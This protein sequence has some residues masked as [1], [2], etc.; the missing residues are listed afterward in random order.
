MV[1]G[2]L[3]SV[4]D[5]PVESPSSTSASVVSEA[6]SLE[7]HAALVTRSVIA[8]SAIT[9]RRRR[10]TMSACLMLFVS[11]RWCAPASVSCP[12]GIKVDVEV[13]YCFVPADANP[14]RSSSVI[15][16]DFG[17][18]SARAVVV[19]SVT[20][21]TL[22]TG[23]SEY[24][25]GV[26]D[27]VL[28]RTGERLPPDW[29]LQVPRDYVESMVAAVRDAM[30]VAQV[31]P[32][33]V[34]GI[35]TDFTACTVLPTTADG[36]P[37]CEL[38]DFADRPHAYVKLWK[39]HAAQSHAD[40]LN[41]IAHERG[42]RW[43]GRY[44]GR[45]SSEWEL[46][47][48][49]QLLEEDPEVY[50]NTARWVEAADW[51]VWQLCGT[52]VRN[53]CATGFKAAWQDGAYPSTAYFAA[54]NPAFERF[55]EEKVDQPI[56]RLGDRA[57]GL[58]AAMSDATRPAGGDRRERRQ[59]RCPRDGSGG[60]G[61]RARTTG[62]HHGHVHLSCDERQRS[63]RRRGHLRGGRGRHRPRT[64]GLRGGP[65]WRRR[66]LRLVRRSSGAAIGAR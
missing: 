28:P 44:G 27:T 10:R 41:R 43:I 36:T 54:V 29:A 37:L 17:T 8:A 25:H 16:V 2:R 20:G 19:D 3:G 18:L 7:E 11:S 50:A 14:P 33:T 60:G 63:A 45:L 6:S 48:A 38:D 46:A 53:A 57:G 26:V 65:E 15:G 49:L 4:D 24:E 40:R 9:G 62:G 59:R 64:V 21:E 58:T 51:I 39:H 55:I 12:A 61:G 1:V 5:V 42:E 23:M 13:E 35:G 30:G 52:Y 32:G 47:K 34:V 66:H 22:G 31:D 56:G